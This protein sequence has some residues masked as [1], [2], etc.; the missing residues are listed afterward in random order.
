MKIEFVEEYL[1]VGYRI[2]YDTLQEF[3]DAR[4][5]YAKELSINTKYIVKD[6]YNAFEEANKRL[7]KVENE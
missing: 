4:W 3:C 1:F 7:K 2:T 6:L 5:D